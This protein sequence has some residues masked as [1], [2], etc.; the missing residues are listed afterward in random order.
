MSEDWSISP[1]LPDKVFPW[2]KYNPV[3]REEVNEFFHSP[4]ILV[5][6]ERMCD[7]GRRLW[8]REYVDGNGGNIS[9]RVAQNLLLCS[10]TLCSKGF[11]TVEDICMVDMDARQ[12]AGI[13]PSTSEVKTHIA[14]MKSVGVNA[15]IHAHPPHCNAFLF[16]GQVPPPASIRKRISSWGTS[17]WPLTERPALWKRHG[18]WRKQPNNPPS[19]SWKTTESL[20]EHVTWKKRNGSWKMRMPTAAWC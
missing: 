7:I 10:P 1:P 3:T 12:K 6:K 2:E 4:E 9:V 13:R 14:M 18:P 17:R 19:F 20:P 11:M 16:A 5:I 8:N 15:C